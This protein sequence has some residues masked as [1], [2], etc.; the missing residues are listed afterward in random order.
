MRRMPF[1]WTSSAMAPP[2]QTIDLKGNTRF[3]VEG[4]SPADKLIELWMPQTC[5]IALSALTLDDT[6]RIRPYED[7]RRKWITYGSSISTA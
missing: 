4:L 2:V 1:R 6:A 5:R 3:S 7:R